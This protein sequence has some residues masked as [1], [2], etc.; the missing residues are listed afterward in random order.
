[1]HTQPIVNA[2]LKEAIAQHNL[3]DD[4]RSNT[5]NQMIDDASWFEFDT[6]VKAVAIL[7]QMQLEALKRNY[8]TRS[9]AL[10]VY[11][12]QHFDTS[13]DKFVEMMI[14][15]ILDYLNDQ[16]DSGNFNLYLLEK[17]KR[18][19]EWFTK[20]DLMKKFNE[21]NGKKEDVFDDDL[22]QYLLDQGVDYPFSRPRS[23]SGE[24][25]IIGM[26]DTENPLVLEVKY[27]DGNSHK[28]D[29]I[30]AGFAQIVKYANDYNKN[31]GYLVIFNTAQAEINIESEDNSKQ[32][33]SRVNFNN[34]N[35]FIIVVDM[36]HEKSASQ[37]GKLRV[38]TITKSE[39]MNDLR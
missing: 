18:K 10:D 36:N 34:K 5:F 37:L 3:S 2:I 8:P 26:I 39:L 11:R 20:K 16:L 33:P 25:D 4:V 14:Q 32:F 27:Y 30:V 29:R 23:A 1:M 6:Q 9:L 31:I 15:P 7:Y 38:E 19:V 24:A 17:Y 35:Y 13:R 21:Y 12:D 28:K 22:R